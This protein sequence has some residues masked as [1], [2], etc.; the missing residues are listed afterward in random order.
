MHVQSPSRSRAIAEADSAIPTSGAHHLC[1]CCRAGPIYELDLSSEDDSD[2]E[3]EFHDSLEEQPPPPKP[4]HLP[5]EVIEHI[6]RWT[7][8]NAEDQTT[9]KACSLVSKAWENPARRILFG[10]CLAITSHDSL[11]R[12]RS[13]VDGAPSL[14]RAVRKLDLSNP[15][16]GWCP[17]RISEMYRR[18]A[19][20]LRQTP[21]VND[22]QL[23]HVALTDKVRHRLFGALRTL[24]VEVASLYSSSWTRQ[25]RHSLTATGG[26]EEAPDMEALAHLLC[27]W[28]RLKHLTISG[29]S[30][31]PRLIRPTIAP[32]HTLPTYH[33]TD[34]AVV[35][36]AL[37]DSTLLWLLGNSA[38]SLRSLNLAATTGLSAEVLSDLFE[39]V[40]P[41]LEN[42][43][44]SVDLDDLAPA[45]SST[46]LNS[47]ILAPLGNLTSFNLSTDSAF[48]EEVLETL[49]T[50]P[51]IR[52]IVLCFPSFSYRVARTATEHASASLRHLTLDSW[53]AADIWTD[54]Q[55]WLVLQECEKRDITFALNGLMKEDI[56]EDWYGEDVSGDWAMLERGAVNVR[57]RLPSRPRRW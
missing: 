10:Q 30:S 33:L 35:S 9:L 48:L 31:Y 28:R 37:P 49:A 29:Y 5:T 40:G 11:Q 26:T 16:S 46:P 56:E 43:F 2:R 39:L 50:L 17:A 7:Q 14:A 44:L 13:V 42:L 23:L 41:T 18:S 3:D 32:L 12:L 38:C 1:I 25:G 53:D 27:T 54:H 34:L 21:N 8:A 51:R 19:G 22:V 6:L 47:S 45:S 15:S 57:R 36:A 24:K 52:S 4:V 20:L 55:R